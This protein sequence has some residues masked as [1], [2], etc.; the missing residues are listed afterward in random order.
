MWRLQ[1]AEDLNDL[2]E[3][4]RRPFPTSAISWRVGAT[5]AKRRKDANDP[6][7]GIPLAYIDARDVMER[8]DDVVGPN[9]WQDAYSVFGSKTIC[10]LSIRIN[11]EWIAKE[12][13]AGDTDTEAEKGALSDAFKRSAV[14]WG[15]GRYLYGLKSD[16]VDIEQRGQSFVLPNSARKELDK[17]HDGFLQDLEWGDRL[18]RNTIRLL[19]IALEYL[20]SNSLEEFEVKHEGT[21]AMLPVAARENLRQRITHIGAARARKEAAE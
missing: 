16:W 9:N 10:S 11:G 20:D 7:K 3:R 4:L 21:I 19:S 12:D 13:G 15:I 6:L 18:D 14:R 1:L 8:L 17:L 2:F 5:N